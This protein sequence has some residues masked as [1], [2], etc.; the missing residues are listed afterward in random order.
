MVG[1]EQYARGKTEIGRN[2][3]K[4]H[5]ARRKN[6][7]KLSARSFDRAARK[8]AFAV[9]DR[10][11]SAAGF[12]AFRQDPKMAER[13]RNDASNRR[14]VKAFAFDLFTYLRADSG[15]NRVSQQ[16]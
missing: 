15:I 7:R 12:A 11:R 4:A 1:L 5:H 8:Q 9:L 13:N 3:F 6:G 2:R 10:S 14:A 16:S